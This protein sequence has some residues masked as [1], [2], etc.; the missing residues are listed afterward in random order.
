MLKGPVLGTKRNFET[1]SVSGSSNCV[2]LIVLS[3]C[4]VPL[5]EGVAVPMMTT[6][7]RE[8]VARGPER[9]TD[10]QIKQKHNW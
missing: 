4:Q 2:S 6:I 10:K 8:L 5:E 3:R 7:P 1:K 9:T